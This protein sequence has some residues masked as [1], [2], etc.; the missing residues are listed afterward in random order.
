[1]KTAEFMFIRKQNEIFAEFHRRLC[2]FKRCI[3][4]M[5]K[6]RLFLHTLWIILESL[7]S[8]GTF[9]IHIIQQADIAVLQYHH[10]YLVHSV[11][12]KQVSP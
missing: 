6:R 11:C 12:H 1:M 3:A 2:Q 9:G 5:K 7:G 10:F 4:F 8:P